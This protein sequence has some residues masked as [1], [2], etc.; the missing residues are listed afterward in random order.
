MGLK[1]GVNVGI[2]I[3]RRIGNFSTKGRFYICLD[4]LL[5][6]LKSLL[7]FGLKERIMGQIA[8]FFYIYFQ[9]NSLYIFH[10]S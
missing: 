5:H 9:K 10:E 3:F 4:T 7:L 8:N 1:S 6:L 2:I